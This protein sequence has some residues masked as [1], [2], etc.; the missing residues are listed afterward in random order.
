MSDIVTCVTEELIFILAVDFCC[1]VAHTAQ[2]WIKSWLGIVEFNTT[3]DYVGEN[4]II[5]ILNHILHLKYFLPTILAGVL[6]IYWIIKV[7]QLKALKIFLEIIFIILWIFM[8]ERFPHAYL[9]YT[10]SQFILHRN[11]LCVL[12]YSPKRK[13]FRIILINITS[14]ALYKSFII[15]IIT[16]GDHLD[17]FNL[18]FILKSFQKALG[19]IAYSINFGIN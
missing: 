6:Y 8:T 14:L 1:T 16:I 9:K 17:H 19:I 18:C 15:F 7:F 4:D 13:Y 5:S 2:R 12:N 11:I 3:F 10:K